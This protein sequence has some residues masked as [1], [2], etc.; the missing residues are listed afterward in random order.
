MFENIQRRKRPR[1]VWPWIVLAV[2]I[3]AV[4]AV[5]MYHVDCRANEYAVWME[6]EGEAEITLEY[7]QSFTDP[8]AHGWRQGKLYHGDVVELKVM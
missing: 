8:G 1:S 2:L 3:V 5:G 6:L 7:G 4:L